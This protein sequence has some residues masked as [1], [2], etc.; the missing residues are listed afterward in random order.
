MDDRSVSRAGGNVDFVVV[1]FGLGALT[2]LSGAVMLAWVAARWQRA[3]ERA[4][5]SADAAYGYAAAAERRGMG[6]AL[7]YSGSAVLL[8]T[9]A[10]LAGS[11]DDRTGA[12]FIATTVTVAALG[13]LFALYRRRFHHSAPPRPHAVSPATMAAPAMPDDAIAESLARLDAEAVAIA[14][15]VDADEGAATVAA[16]V[17]AAANLGE[18]PSDATA[19]GQRASSDDTEVGEE[20]VRRPESTDSAAQRASVASASTRPAGPR[21]SP[22]DEENDTS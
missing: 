7:L 1:G 3:A 21:P 18:A 17:P 13:V 9:I 12:F 5:S 14:R 15:S 10:A 4:R 19:A 6:L 11:L 20:D 22:P 16:S 8:A 2:I